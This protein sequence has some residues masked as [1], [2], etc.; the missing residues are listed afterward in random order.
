[1]PPLADAV[2]FVDGDQS[3]VRVAQDGPEGLRFEPF[4]R[5][6]EDV[7]PPGPGA[8]HDVRSLGSALRGAQVGR[9]NLPLEALRCVLTARPIEGLPG[10]AR[11]RP[12]HCWPAD[13]EL[14]AERLM[15]LSSGE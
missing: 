15:L 14:L 2:G 6:E 4:G 9:R 8:L 7:Q 11:P 12:P 13:A 1:M 10:V 3:Y 5:H